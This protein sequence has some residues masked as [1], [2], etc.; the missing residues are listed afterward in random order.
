MKEE[1]NDWRMSLLCGLLENEEEQKK[2]RSLMWASD[3]IKDRT[4]F[5]SS[6]F[7]NPYFFDSSQYFIFGSRL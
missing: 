4:F 6:S 1:N 5:C 7:S 2:M 3:H